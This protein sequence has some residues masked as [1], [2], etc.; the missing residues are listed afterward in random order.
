MKIIHLV[1][2]LQRWLHFSPSPSSQVQGRLSSMK[3]R[4]VVASSLTWIWRITN[5]LVY[6]LC[7]S[8]CPFTYPR[9]EVVQ[10]PL[11]VVEGLLDELWHPLLPVLAEGPQDGQTLPVRDAGVPNYLGGKVLS[12][13]DEVSKQLFT[14]GLCMVKKGV[15]GDLRKHI[16]SLHQQ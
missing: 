2:A 15:K 13:Q 6:I 5:C 16:D 8:N 7:S 4:S 10:Q 9:V 14:C 11:L 1:S 12:C 3:K